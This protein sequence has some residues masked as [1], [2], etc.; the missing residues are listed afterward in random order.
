MEVTLLRKLSDIDIQKALVV[1]I[2][3]MTI[4]PLAYAS[5][6]HMKIN[7]L[8]AEMRLMLSYLSSLQQS[9]HLE[10][11]RYVGF[12]EW[13]GARIRGEDNCRQPEGAARLGFILRWCHQEQAA[14]IR[15]AYRV[16]LHE[17]RSAFRAVAHSG[18]D[19][20][21][22]SFVCF[23]G[24]QKDRWSKLNSQDIQAHE[25]CH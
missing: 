14:E 4:T 18:S 11:G 1:F 20:R 25:S 15:Y 5:Y 9:Q 12:D 13:Y 10:S 21:D 17:D 8:R 22:R 7:S 23:F 19:H 3:A 2:L 6:Y 16:K 24:D